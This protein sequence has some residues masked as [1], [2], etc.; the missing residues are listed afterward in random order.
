MTTSA[1]KIFDWVDSDNDSCFSQL[2]NIN[3]RSA[4]E[5]WKDSESIRGLK[6]WRIVNF[7]VEEWPQELYGQFYS[8]DTYIILHAEGEDENV[9]RDIHVWIGRNSSQDEYGSAAYKL[10]ELDKYLGGAA[11]QHREVQGMESKAFV[12]Y[13]QCFMLLNGGAQS[14]FNHVD[15]EKNTV[16]T[17][18]YKL[19]IHGDNISGREIPLSRSK[20]GSSDIFLLST[21]SV[22]FIWY[23]KDSNE[24]DRYQALTYSQLVADFLKERKVLPLDEGAETSEFL[25][26]LVDDDGPDGYDISFYVTTQTDSKAIFRLTD[27]SG[28]LE[29][30]EE[31]ADKITSV[32]DLNSDDIYIID[33]PFHCYV[34]IGSGASRSEKKNALIYAHRMLRKSSHPCAPVSI[35]LQGIENPGFEAAITI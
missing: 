13:F 23:G 24:T 20:L 4:S 17:R 32:A 18:L 6:I 30:V 22:V 28:K 31:K 21:D 12:A 26:Y 9:K 8:G 33:T 7:C 34:W 5:E 19:V 14:G 3:E 16:T 15:R 2:P 25:L 35:V 10:V 1:E 27:V 29:F 11:T